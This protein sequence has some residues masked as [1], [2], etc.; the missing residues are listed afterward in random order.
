MDITFAKVQ[1]S[2]ND[3]IVLDNRQNRLAEKIRDFAQFAAFAC[4]RKYSVGADG[5]L[6]LEDSG[7]CDFRM[8]IFNPDGSE[9]DMCGNGIRCSALY[10]YA[11]E[12]CGNIMKIETKAGHLESEVSTGTDGETNGRNAASVSVK[13]TAPGDIKLNQNLGIEK[14]IVNV[15]TINSGV[16]HAVHFVENINS[17]PVKEMGGKIRYHKIFEPKGTNADFVEVLGGSNI[18]VR[19]YERGVEDETLACGT[20][21]VASAII[22]HL[23]NGTKGPVCVTTKSGEAVKVRFRKEQN[24]FKDVYLEGKAQIVFEGSIHY[25]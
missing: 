18:S 21:V 6:V 11:K 24:R 17:Y 12:W 8:R 22:S 9:V 14:S 25:V 2:G 7:S 10:A 5:L 3:F 1:A 13:M 16:P 15:H 23:I 19:T 4:R 20:G